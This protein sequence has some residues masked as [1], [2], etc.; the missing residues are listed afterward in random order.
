MKPI[1]QEFIDRRNAE[2]RANSA[3]A[4]AYHYQECERRVA[5]RRR[6]DCAG[7]AHW[8]SVFHAAREG[9]NK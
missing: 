6:S 1:P 9:L 8:L 5:S 4:I 3:Q 2:R 7:V